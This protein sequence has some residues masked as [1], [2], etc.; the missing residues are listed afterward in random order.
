MPGDMDLDGDVDLND[1]ATFANCYMGA[2]VPPAPGCEI[3]DLDG[4]NDVDLAD[5]STFAVN[6]TG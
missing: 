6:Y 4:D 2:S 1:F 5:F 3:C